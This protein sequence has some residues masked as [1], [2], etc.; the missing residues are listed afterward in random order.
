MVGDLL[1]AGVYTLALFL[2]GVVTISGQPGGGAAAVTAGPAGDGAA[3][4]PGGKA[5]NRGELTILQWGI[6]EGGAFA[7]ILIILFFYRRDWKAA[8]E[9]W[10]DQHTVTTQALIEVT[11]AQT[12]TA[13]ALRE[14]TQALRQLRGV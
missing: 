9:F 13:A 3:A 6:R 7:V 14:N 1:R 2:V 4:N 8:T 11:K 12:D 10:K 5:V